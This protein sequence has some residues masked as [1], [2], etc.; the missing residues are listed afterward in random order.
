MKANISLWWNWPEEDDWGD[1][2]D[3]RD[4]SGGGG[5]ETTPRGDSFRLVDLSFSLSTIFVELIFVGG[6]V[7]HSLRDGLRQVI[8]DLSSSLSVSIVWGSFST[9]GGSVEKGRNLGLEV[10]STFEELSSD[11]WCSPF[12]F[13][14]VFFFG[15]FQCVGQ[16]CFRF[17]RP[18]FEVVVKSSAMKWLKF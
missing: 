18:F 15:H 16:I 2:N 3:V 12:V 9:F 17:C 7:R 14:D 5:G 10:R 13:V 8:E 6:G 4:D 1:E 11:F